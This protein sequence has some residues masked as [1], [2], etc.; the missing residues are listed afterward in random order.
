MS[1]RPVPTV[2]ATA[3]VAAMQALRSAE[4]AASEA[5]SLCDE[6]VPE[7]LI[8]VRHREALTRVTEA[9]TALRKAQGPAWAATHTIVDSILAHYDFKHVGAKRRSNLVNALLVP[10][11]FAPLARELDSVAAP[12]SIVLVFCREWRRFHAVADDKHGRPQIGVALNK[13][14]FGAAVVSL[15]EEPIVNADLSFLI[16]GWQRQRGE[17]VPEEDIQIINVELDL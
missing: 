14:T 1:F 5:M 3:F 4:S 9:A 2:T 12:A 6:A 7:T 13:P 17:T 16:Y 8:R 15:M 10:S 11:S